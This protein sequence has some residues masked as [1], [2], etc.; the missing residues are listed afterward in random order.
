MAAKSKSKAKGKRDY[1]EAFEAAWKAYP[2]VKGRSSKPDS[3]TH[4]RKLSAEDRAALP[5]AVQRYAR[6]G[7]EPKMECGAPAMDRWLK[8]EKHADWLVAA[9][10][11]VVIAID[12]AE[13]ARRI[14]LIQKMSA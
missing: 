12:P 13:Q 6:E 9:P 7:R 8:H 5:Q 10:S 4:W 3:L 2:H 11:A 1:P 14:A